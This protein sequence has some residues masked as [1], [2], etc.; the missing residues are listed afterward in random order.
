MD[1][2][3]VGRMQMIT[4]IILSEKIN[5]NAKLQ[6]VKE[7]PSLLYLDADHGVGHAMASRAVEM[8]IIKAKQTGVCATSMYNSG[9]WGASGA[10][11]YEIAQAGLFGISAS[12]S[13]LCLAAFGG[14][15]PTIG[16][17]P[18]SMAFPGSEK[19]NFP[20]MFDMACSI[21]AVGKLQMAL[22]KGEAIPEGW[23]IDKEGLPITDPLRAFK[24]GICLLPFGGV[25]GYVIAT[26]IEIL[27]SVLS[28]S[29]RGNDVGST[30]VINKDGKP[31]NVGHFLLAIDIEQFR[32]KADINKD[33]D[34]FIDSIKAD[35]P[36]PGFKEVLVPGELEAITKA[37][38]ESG[39][40][41]ITYKVG[42][43]ML[44]AAKNCN[45]VS[46]NATVK[47]LFDMIK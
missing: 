33:L 2:H 45:Y 38:R 37:A 12:N 14:T 18:W 46:D 7:T 29:A 30:L 5:L 21:V 47:D 28:G 13:G 36:A 24:E 4:N 1:T 39:A 15:N 40:F 41:E 6:I 11:A 44:M 22:R 17:S 16:N 35:A 23:V 19:Y 34:A 27:T 32:S 42:E 10:Y 25:K 31:E 20:I 43:E 8:T 3:G 26:L 9:F